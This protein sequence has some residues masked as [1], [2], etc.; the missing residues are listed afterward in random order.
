MVKLQE[1]RVIEVK[2]LIIG[3]VLV[4]CLLVTVSCTS[5]ATES[6]VEKEAITQAEEEEK[7]TLTEEQQEL[8]V[9]RG[10]LSVSTIE[11]A[12]RLAGYQVATPTFIPEGFL[13]G[14]FELTL[15]V[16]ADRHKYGLVSP[17]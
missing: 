13:P 9:E 16:G 3:L 6:E 14:N 4:I 15:F 7:P 2:R 11:D 1:A 12:S 8:W 5:E 10:V 17:L